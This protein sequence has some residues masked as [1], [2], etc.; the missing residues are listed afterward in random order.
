MDH[1]LLKRFHLNHRYIMRQIGTSDYMSLLK[2]HN[3]E[4]Q[5]TDAATRSE[6]AKVLARKNITLGVK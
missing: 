6:L 5:G 4:Y 2:E 3:V 1:E